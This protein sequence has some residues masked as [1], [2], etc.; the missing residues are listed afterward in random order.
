MLA[1]SLHLDLFVHSLNTLKPLSMHLHVFLYGH[2]LET[3]LQMILLVLV[4]G[5]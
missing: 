3:K 2:W 5:L 1:D 4:Y